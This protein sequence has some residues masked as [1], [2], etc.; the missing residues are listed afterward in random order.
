MFR[1]HL[2]ALRKKKTIFARPT[3]E[4]TCRLG[5]GCCCQNS[6]YSCPISGTAT[7]VAEYC[8]P[9]WCRSVNTRLI[10][11]VLYDALRI[12]TECLR[13]DSTD[14]LQCFQVSSQLS[15]LRATLSLVNGA[16]LDP[17]QMLTS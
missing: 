5:M 4:T 1:H 10:D 2:V 17:D 16:S 13:P 9:V 11:S 7:L 3:A 8:P 14:H 12:V 6:M 15:K